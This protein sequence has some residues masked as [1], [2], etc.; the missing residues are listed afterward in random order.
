MT[1]AT[2]FVG[3][4][5]TPLLPA[6]GHHVVEAGRRAGAS[7]TRFVAVG[8][9]DGA[10]DWRDALDGVDA[11]VHLAGLAHRDAGDADEDAYFA[12]NDRGAAKLAADA[13][14]AGVRTFVSVSSIFAKFVET[15]PSAY[16]RSKLAGEAHVARF[17]EGQG[18]CGI[19]LRPS[20]V[21]AWDAAA[22]W[23][24]LQRLAA[25]GLPLPFGA[26][27]NRRS[28]CAVENLCDAI[29]VAVE[30]GMQGAAGGSYEIADS[31]V[32]SLAEII[33]WLRRGMDMPARLVPVPPGLL[34]LAGAA[35]GKSELVATLTGDMVVD[36]SDFRRDFGWRP[37]TASP[38]GVA[39]SGR[40]FIETVQ[41]KAAG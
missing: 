12:V 29:A 33:I 27:R 34:R 41:S 24:R 13:A 37:L 11:V 39:R 15:R 10:T 21:Y 18:R 2:G 31:E 30:A 4:R 20:L 6:R 3:R 5:L 14:A 1:G 38:E 26:V 19:V 23:N 17:G 16:A 32:V 9:I 28:L 22:N 35:T 25:S 8:E 7:G 36:A 40:L